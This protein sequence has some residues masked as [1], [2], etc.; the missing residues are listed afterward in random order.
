MSERYERKGRTVGARGLAVVAAG[1]LAAAAALG[2]CGGGG[3]A[4]AARGA[5]TAAS[6]RTPPAAPADTAAA[7]AV[8]DTVGP[9]GMRVTTLD[10]DGHPVSAEIAET[11]RDRQEGLMYRD[12]LPP[13]HGMLFVYPEV[14][15][16]SFW[17]R[18]TR[19]PLDIAFVDPTGRIVDIQHMSP[20]SDSLHTSARPAMY[21][22]EM[23]DGWFEA[24][25][26]GIGDRVGF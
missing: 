2:A 16:L 20:E 24:H 11:D 21:A 22:L 26:V 7:A 25:G 6:D 4:P 23:A 12:S 17:M 3:G 9:S 18:N 14:Q 8:T 19:I 10:V 5:G 15:T 1:A 13:D